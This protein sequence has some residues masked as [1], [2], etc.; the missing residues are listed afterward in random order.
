MVD[1]IVVKESRGFIA[2]SMDGPAYDEFTD[3]GFG[4]VF[5]ELEAWMAARDLKP[6]EWIAYFFDAPDEA[7][8]E[9]RSK[10]CI[11]FEGDATPSGGV[12]I[13]EHA[14]EL[15]AAFKTTLD[16]VDGPEPL[17]E[18]MFRWIEEN[19]YSPSSS[20]YVREIYPVNPWETPESE[21][22][23]EFQ[24]PIVKKG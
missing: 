15:V 9:G 2:A 16:A 13:E 20:A 3:E 8:E 6:L 22:E 7:S 5:K 17:Y 21:T 14:S 12:Q 11:S 1:E 19:G 18:K 10:A 23:V 4:E 24:I